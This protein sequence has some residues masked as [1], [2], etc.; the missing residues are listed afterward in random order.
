MRTTTDIT[1]AV[2]GQ[3][4]TYRVAEGRPTSATFEVFDATAGDDGTADFSGTATVDSVSTTVDVAS[5]RSQ[6]DPQ[7]LSLAA[8]TSIATGTR[9][10]LSEGSKRE[11]VEPIEIVSGDYIRVRHPLKNDYTT[12]ATLVGTTI[13]AAVDATW[14]ADEANLSEHLDP[15]PGY[16]VRWA[17]TFAG[18]VL[19]RYS[20]FDLVRAPIRAQVDIDDLDERAP[21]LIDTLPPQY[22]GDQGRS[23]VAAGERSLVARLAALDVDTDAIRDDQIYDELVLMR[24]LYVL[25]MGGWH[26]VSFSALEYVK[27]TTD[28][29]DRFLEQHLAVV[30]RVAMAPGTSGGVDV[31]DAR[32]FWSK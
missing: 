27:L 13:T 8:T 4:L 29:F 17:I 11:W 15:D 26:P 5:G 30:N 20:F 14:V 21:G 1:Y 23:I 28:T 3:T 12:A 10:L 31:V 22:A 18:A 9:Y 6:I 16:R 2:T 7:K 24:A 25:A 19:I 32:P